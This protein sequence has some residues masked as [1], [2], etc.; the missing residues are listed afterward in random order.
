[1]Y[2]ANCVRCR[3]WYTNA[4]TMVPAEEDKANDGDE[5]E[6]EQH[7]DHDASREAR[8]RGGAA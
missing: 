3:Q 6:H 7:E 1:M 2:I 4:V 5:G 8:R